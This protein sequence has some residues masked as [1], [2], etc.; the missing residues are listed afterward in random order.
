[1]IYYRA[2]DIQN[3]KKKEREPDKRPVYVN[4]FALLAIFK[5]CNVDIEG[6]MSTVNGVCFITKINSTLGGSTNES[7]THQ[8]EVVIN[9]SSEP[10][11]TT[12]LIL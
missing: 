7:D 10:Y 8:R 12:C 1:M 2:L 3:T 4:F 5:A 11:K 9:C 6:P